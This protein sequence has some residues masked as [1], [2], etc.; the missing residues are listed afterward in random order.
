MNESDFNQ[1]VDETLLAIEEAIDAAGA[2]IDYENSGGV[3]TLIIEAN[4][5]QIIINRQT[6]LRQLWLACRSG[7][8]HFDWSTEQQAWLLDSDATPF[9]EMLNRALIDQDGA[10]LELT[11]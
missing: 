11:A 7:G 8:Y 1:Q 6:P 10:A 3:L 5:S 9:D 4:G 2:D